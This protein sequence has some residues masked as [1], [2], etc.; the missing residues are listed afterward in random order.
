MRLFVGADYFSDYAKKRKKAG[1]TLH[2]I[3]TKEQDKQALN[4]EQNLEQLTTSVTEK[5][6]IRYAPEELA[7]PMTMYMF[8]DKLAI[9][10]TKEE[11]FAAII[12][13]KELASMQ[14]KLFELLWRSLDQ[15]KIKVGI[16]H[17]LTGTMAISE[18]SL[19]DAE[20][21]AIEEINKA[22]GVLGK[23]LEPIVKDSES[24]PEIFVK[25]LREASLGIGSCVVQATRTLSGALACKK[26]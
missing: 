20:R 8:D 2:A 10:S 16:L 1:F 17:S 19:V 24:D 7:F 15:S 4:A 9:I 22:G 13:S 23:Q 12:Q 3:R 5:R 18:R 14:R 25:K 6:E 26:S 21:M 11:S